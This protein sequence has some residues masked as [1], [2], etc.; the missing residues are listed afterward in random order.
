MNEDFDVAACPRE[1]EIKAFAADPLKEEWADLAAHIVGCDHCR[2]ALAAVLD[3]G[4]DVSTTSEEDAFMADFISR[5]CRR[6]TASERVQAFVDSRRMS[7]ISTHER[8]LLAAVPAA[9]GGAEESVPCSPD[10]EVHF[11]FAGGGDEDYWRAELA[12]PPVAGPETML[13]VRVTGRGDVPVGQGMLRLAG[14]LLP[15]SDGAA[16]LPFSLFLDGLRDTDVSLAR[17]GGKP[18]AGRLLFF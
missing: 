15:L 1:S 3:V 17:T 11:V 8:Y 12:I 5:N 13:N 2:D 6:L 18:V 4:G 16:D 10:E 9:G 7:F 14:C